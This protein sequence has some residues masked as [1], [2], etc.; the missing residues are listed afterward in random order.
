[1]INGNQLQ[2]SVMI[3][4]KNIFLLLLIMTLNSC[5]NEIE[6]FTPLQHIKIGAKK[7]IVL[8]QIENYKTNKVISASNTFYLDDIEVDI[9]FIYCANCINKKLDAIKLQSKNQKKILNILKESFDIDNK[10]ISIG[11]F[12]I[13][14]SMDILEG[15]QQ[16]SVICI[17]SSR[18]DFYKDSNVLACKRIETEPCWTSR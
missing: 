12:S 14:E 5:N 6:L 18:V 1:M 15:F 9:S 17:Y 13:A 11:V 7:N 3:I 10:K 16:D 8:K 2:N 4:K